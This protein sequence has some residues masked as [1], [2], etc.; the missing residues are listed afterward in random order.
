[1]S[2]LDIEQ[3][4]HLNICSIFSH[5]NRVEEITVVIMYQ[6]CFWKQI[7]CVIGMWDILCHS[8]VYMM[9]ITLYSAGC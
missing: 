4:E 3:T 8:P 1:M 6:K 7:C 2:M 5:D 9:V